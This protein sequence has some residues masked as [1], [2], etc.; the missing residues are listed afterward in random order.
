MTGRTPD[1]RRILPG[2]NGYAPGIYN[3]HRKP[4]PE[5]RLKPLPPWSRSAKPNRTP[6]YA[7][8]AIRRSKAFSSCKCGGLWTTTSTDEDNAPEYLVVLH[9]PV[10]RITGV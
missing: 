4:G 6:A 5:G 7:G 3:P 1:C 2:T 9:A 10:I 8:F